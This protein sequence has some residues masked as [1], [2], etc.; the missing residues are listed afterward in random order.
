MSPTVHCMTTILPIVNIRMTYVV[1]S[2]IILLSFDLLNNLINLIDY[3][4]FDYLISLIFPFPLLTSLLILFLVTTCHLF[5]VLFTCQ[6]EP[7]FDCVL[8]PLKSL[9]IVQVSLVVTYPLFFLLVSLCFFIK[10]LFYFCS[11]FC[12]TSLPISNS[13]SFKLLLELKLSVSSLDI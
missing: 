8:K 6:F 3:L 1:V 7:I 13:F 12:L 2:G 10:I 9:V 4:F 11:N 5:I